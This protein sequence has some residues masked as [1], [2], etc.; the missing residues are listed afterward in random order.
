MSEENET[1]EDVSEL[2]KAA[3]GGR[4]AKAEAALAKRELAFVKAGIDTDSKPAQ[5]LLKNYEG[6]LDVESIKAEA[7]EW[8][9]VQATSEPTPETEEPQVETFT[10][11]AA[12]QAMR[13]AV[14]GTPAPDTPKPVGGV[15]AAFKQFLEDREEG[16]SQL[17]ATNRAFGAVI[18]AAAQGD[19]QAVFDP[20]K[21]EDKAARYGHGAEHAR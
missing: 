13:E 21:W 1:Q 8:G 7:A 14:S 12:Q 5:A 20:Q 6:D 16:V 11:A 17:E 19:P 4:A 9:L 3:E 15:D 10:E 18:K 2:R